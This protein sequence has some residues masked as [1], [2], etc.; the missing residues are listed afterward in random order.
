MWNYVGIVRSDR[1]LE[2]GSQRINFIQEE[3]NQYYWD[4]LLTGDTIELRNIATVADLI[5][6]CAI[7]RKETRGLHYI[8]DHP[9]PLEEWKTDTVIKKGAGFI[10]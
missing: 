8:L 3:V 5:I 1:R 9:E 7:H 6:K 2:R 10:E 4:F